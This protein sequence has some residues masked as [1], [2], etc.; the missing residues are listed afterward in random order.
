MILIIDDEPDLAATCERLLQRHGYRVMTAGSY[1]AG[2]AALRTI[3]LAMVI[4]DVGLPDGDG[5]D[6]VREARRLPGRLP[7]IVMSGRVSESGRRAALDAGADAY[8][9]KPFRTADFA[10]LVQKLLG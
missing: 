9:P 8:V 2:Q 1:A 3:P 6:L 7:V 5:L 10:A 4:A